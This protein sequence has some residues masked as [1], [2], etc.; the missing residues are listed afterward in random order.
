MRATADDED[1][2][3][4][5]LTEW[6]AA[7]SEPFQGWDFSRLTGRMSD[8]PAPWSYP[9]LARSAMRES[10]SVLD[11]G[12]A[13]GEMLLSMRADW[14][15][16]V[17]ATEGWRPNLPLAEQALEPHG[18]RVLSYDAD[19]GDRLPLPDG[20]VDLI[21]NRHE[22]FDA[23]VARV[24]A[25]GGRFLTQ[26]V[27]ASNLAELATMLG[28]ARI[29][30]TVRVQDLS[31]LLV[32]AGLRLERTQDWTGCTTFV[33]VAALVYYL[34]AVPFTAPADFSVDRYAEALLGLHAAGPAQ[35][36]PIVLTQHRFLIIATKGGAAG[37]GR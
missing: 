23:D 17:L 15:S 36:E 35:G 30:A 24:L 14:P 25:P 34:S 26:Q 22:A 1:R 3:A 27:G 6:R 20:E 31:E 2:T 32:G 19:A 16:R 18:V 12:T 13:A 8:E 7:A 28:P 37:T 21:I 5:L 9:E 10:T 11:M 29:P 33:D 4:G